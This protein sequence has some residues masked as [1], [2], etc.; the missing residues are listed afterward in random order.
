MSEPTTA[1]AGDPSNPLNLRD[2]VDAYYVPIDD[3]RFEPTLH[4]QGAWLPHEQHMAPV[5]GLITHCL[6]THNPREDLQ[7]ARLTFEILGVM[8]AARTTVECSTIRS[9]RTIELDEATLSIDGTV[10]VRARAWRLARVDT[11]A[12]AEDPTPAIPGPDELP[13]ADLGRTWGGGFI[14]SLDFRAR[15]DREPGRGQAWIRP[16]KQLVAGVDVDPVAAFVGVVDTAN[17]VATRLDPREWMLPNTDLSIH[18]YREPVAGWVGF[19]TSVAIGDSGV[20]L[21]SS[22]LHDARGAVG[23]SEQILTVRPMPARR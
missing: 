13:P 19:D 6:Q 11:A 20:G 9:G 15:A 17:G 2:D 3:S 14:S 5:A 12:V 22:A 7:I 18:L 16:S 23:R 10:A 1:S 21:T 4:V 8:P